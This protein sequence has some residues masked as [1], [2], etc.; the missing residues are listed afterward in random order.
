LTR[1]KKVLKAADY[2]E[3]ITRKTNQKAIWIFRKV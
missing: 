1:E 3:A 2:P